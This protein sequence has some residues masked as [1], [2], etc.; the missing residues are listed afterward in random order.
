MGPLARL[1]STDALEPNVVSF[2]PKPTCLFKF[3]KDEGRCKEKELANERCVLRIDRL[4]DVI[5][6]Q[7]MQRSDRLCGVI[8]ARVS[9]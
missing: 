3:Y 1:V 9:W 6:S 7:S 4:R 5:S 2:R 8:T